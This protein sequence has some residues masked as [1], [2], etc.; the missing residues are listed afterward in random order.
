MKS[1]KQIIKE[2]EKEIESRISSRAAEYPTC[3][4]CHGRIIDWAD[5]EQCE[6][7]MNDDQLHDQYLDALGK[8]EK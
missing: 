3:Y 1:L 6:I 8:K 7:E 4:W 2:N 5:H